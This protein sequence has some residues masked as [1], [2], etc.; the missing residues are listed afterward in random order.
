MDRGVDAMYHIPSCTYIYI[1]IYTYVS[2]YIIYICI[3]IYIY[4]VYI[5]IY[6]FSNPAWSRC[7]NVP[8]EAGS[9]FILC[10]RGEAQCQPVGG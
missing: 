8:A 6:V 3:Y 2:I 1:Y 10:S 7:S 4:H 9:T 5:Y